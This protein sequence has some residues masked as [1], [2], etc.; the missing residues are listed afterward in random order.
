MSCVP[1][2]NVS[3]S[4]RFVSFRIVSFRYLSERIL[5]LNELWSSA[6]LQKGEVCQNVAAVSNRILHTKAYQLSLK[7][8]LS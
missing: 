3:R 8:H 4:V 7:T 5:D 1:L 2:C 6:Y